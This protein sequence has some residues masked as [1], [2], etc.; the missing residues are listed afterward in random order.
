M[1]KVIQQSRLAIPVIKGHGGGQAEQF[2]F[3]AAS[4][5][6]RACVFANEVCPLRAPLGEIYF[7]FVRTGFAARCP[8]HE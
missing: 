1:R 6:D 4:R 8:E 2:A 3:I 7:G 5:T